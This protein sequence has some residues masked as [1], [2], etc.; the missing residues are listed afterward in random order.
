MPVWSGVNVAG[1]PIAGELDKTG[2][3]TEW[4]SL[5]SEVREDERRGMD[6]V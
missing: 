5:H 4:K 3:G 6:V 2:D 1:V